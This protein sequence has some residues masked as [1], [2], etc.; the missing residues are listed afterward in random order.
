LENNQQTISW[1]L[2]EIQKFGYVYDT[3]YL[4]HD[5]A[6]KNLG[7]GRSIEEIF[8]ASGAKIQI[9]ERVPVVD[10]INAARTIFNK[11]YFDRQKCED[12]LNCLRHYRYDVDPET[13]MFSQKPIHDQNSHGADAFGMLGL[14]VNEPRKPRPVKKNYAP[15]GNWMG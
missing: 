11:C 12:G 7:T 9:L 5:A 1:Y 2:A 4:P 13:G 10:S 6:A 14:M 8:R 3:H 15:M